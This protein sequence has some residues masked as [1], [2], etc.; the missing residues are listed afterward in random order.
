MTHPSDI[1]YVGLDVHQQM[2]E[3]CGLD[4]A[5]E[6]RVRARVKTRAPTLR[7][8]FAH[9]AP[10]AICLEAG[11]SSPWVARLLQDLGHDVVVCHPRQIQLIAQSRKKTDRRD[12]ELLARL[13]R[14]DRALLHPVTVRSAVTQQGRAAL[15]MRHTL[16]GARTR[17][18]Q[19]VRGVLRGFGFR[20]PRSTW[21][22]LVE[23]VQALE[24]PDGLPPLLAPLL[25]TIT[26]LTAQIAQLEQEL[27]KIARTHPVVPQ[28]RAIPGIGP[29]SALA[30]VLAVEDPY[31][32]RKSRDVASFLGLCPSIRAS[33]ETAHRG[34][35]TKEGDRLVRFLLGQAA[36]ACVR[37]T[38]PSALRDWGLAV[39]ARRG[40]PKGATALARKLAVV[41]HRLWVT[42]AAY[43]PYP[44]P[45]QAA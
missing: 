43:E 28:L 21:G 2:T 18:M 38:R 12:A 8:W 31:R 27:A 42:G 15:A 45:A 44:H 23:R 33:G 11:G 10:L 13:L 36:H 9:R 14:A 17:C 6:V 4:D 34:R 5:G 3:I 35:I 16:V 39:R 25:T 29:L 32:F 7:R 20:V 26:E 37:S 24:L 41:M 40:V 1:L 22:Q 19:S 30:F